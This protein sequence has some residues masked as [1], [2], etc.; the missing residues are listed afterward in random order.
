MS[1]GTWVQ[2][3]KPYVAGYHPTEA[4]KVA[5]AKRLATGGDPRRSWLG[6]PSAGEVDSVEVVSIV[7][8]A[9]GSATITYRRA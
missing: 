2:T 4:D 8:D 5:A 3:I 9:D 1:A 7:E 6:R